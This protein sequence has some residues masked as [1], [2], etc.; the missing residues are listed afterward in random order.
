MSVLGSIKRQLKETSVYQNKHIDKFMTITSER[1]NS[2]PDNEKS[3]I[4]FSYYKGDKPAQFKD[5]LNR[6][7]ITI[8]PE[9]RYQSWIDTGLVF[10][11]LGAMTDNIPP[12]YSLIIDNSINDLISENQKLDNEVAKT[13]IKVL[14]SVSAY[15]DRIID[16]LDVGIK[17]HA[18]DPY[19]RKTREYFARM[20]TEKAGSLEEALQRVLFWSS[21]FWQTRH[22][23]IG[24]GRLDKIL[25][26]FSDTA[27]KE[28]IKDFLIELHRYYGFKSNRVSLGDTG[29]IIIL[30]G[31]NPDGAYFYNEL[32]YAFIKA[33][34][35]VHLP[36]PKALLRV[37]SNMPEDL[38]KLALETIE[39]GIGC[40]LLSNDEVVIPALEKFGYSHDDACNYVTSA[41]WEPL[42]YGKCLEKNNIG[43]INYAKAFN[44]TCTDEHFVE[45]KSFEEVYKLFLEHVKKEADSHK[46]IFDNI[47]WEDDPLMTL[48]T[49]GC[50]QSGKDIS[51][52]GAVY[53]DYGILTV[54]MGNAIDSL[55]HIKS[56]VFGKSADM[57][58]KDVQQ[59]IASDYCDEVTKKKL[60]SP[61]YYCHDDEEIIEMVEEIKSVVLSSYKDYRNPL[62]GKIK[63]G[64]SSSNYAEAGKDTGATFDGRKANTPLTV[65]ISSNEGIP[66]TE[67]ISFASKLD[68]SGQYSNG[69]VVDY[70]VSPAFMRSNFDKFMLFIKQSIRMGFF[71]MQMN[72]VD[73]KTLIEAQKH[74]EQFPNLIVRVWGFS[75]YFKDLPKYYQDTLIRR[76]VESEKAA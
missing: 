18:S 35:E 56:R 62:G 22:R 34:K 13:N 52:G 19:L 20:K 2:L 38:L 54:G 48:F 26:R 67:L 6:L 4:K 29:Q 44:E 3:E 69:N 5:A 1:Y 15:I 40:P 30:G 55:Q 65:H 42:S 21:M 60:S 61:C 66:Y 14:T 39:T 28:V 37:S 12:K 7:Q 75:A 70:F 72:V 74:P 11:C 25:A 45:C 46:K 71:Q 8:T 47:I 53:N 16:K 51:K 23:L 73:S 31:K 43:D 41:C 50:L 10:V 58:L 57:T 36:D 49:D 27:D 59:T 9:R 63:W 68:Y 32:T 24:L 33:I 17:N 64:L 76:A